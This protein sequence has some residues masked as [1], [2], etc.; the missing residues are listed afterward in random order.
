[1]GEIGEIWIGGDG[2]A[3]G[4]L[5]RADLS[6]E[7][8]VPDPFAADGSRMYRSGDLGSLRDGLLYF[9][10]RVDQ[11]I[12]LRGYRIE[13]GDIEAAAL[14]ESGVRA[15]V[16]VVH[17]VGPNDQRLVLYVVSRGADPTLAERLREHLREQ[18]PPYMLP[19]HIEWLEAL[20]QTPNGKIDRNALPPPAVAAGQMH[21]T[22]APA[23]TEVRAN[24]LAD[25]REE[26]LAAIW[27]ELIGVEDVRGGDN[28]FDLG[29]HS[30]LAVEFSTRVQRETSVRLALLDIAT[31]TLALLATELPKAALSRTSTDM[32]SRS[33]SLL[34]RLRRRLG[35]R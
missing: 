5:F 33:P 7:R 13:P 6:A 10:G 4:Y 29:G 26:Y 31:G 9:H 2:V 22:V 11:Q 24:A 16:A 17:T 27:R 1:M 14:A 30:L 3:D 25:P 8:F 28:F 32:G 19:Q 35:L 20:P 15:A 21:R 34:A 18:L 23:A 12:K